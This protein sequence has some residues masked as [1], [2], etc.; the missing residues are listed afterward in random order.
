VGGMKPVANANNGG[1][2]VECGRTFQAV[3]SPIAE[4][5]GLRLVERKMYPMIGLP[6]D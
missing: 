3:P 2:G 1:P 4:G 5:E 6:A